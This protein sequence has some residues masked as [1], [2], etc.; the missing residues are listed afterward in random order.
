[1]FYVLSDVLFWN[2]WLSFALSRFSNNELA[3]NEDNYL[4]QCL[5]EGKWSCG[6]I[7]RGVNEVDYIVSERGKV[8]L[9]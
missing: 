5:R 7:L 9:W 2:L 1:M 3:T 6:D 4:H 8:V